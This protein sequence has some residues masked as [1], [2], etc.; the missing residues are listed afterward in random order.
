LSLL[1]RRLVGRLRHSSMSSAPKEEEEAEIQSPFTKGLIFNVCSL[2]PIILVSWATNT[3]RSAVVSCAVNYIVFAIHA[4]P[5]SSEKFFDATGTLTY[6]SLTVTAVLLSPAFEGFTFDLRQLVLGS[7]VLVWSIRLGSYLLGRICRDGK[8]ARF[9]RLKI[10]F[11]LWLGVWSMQAL[12]CYLVALPALIIISKPAGVF[13]SPSILDLVGWSIWVIGMGFEVIADRQK[14]AWRMLPE[15]KGRF[16]TVGL[17]S[18]SR[19]PNY[20]GEITLW[21][22]VCVSG[23]SSFTGFELLAWFSPVTTFILLNYV[24]GV[25][26]LEKTADERWGNEPAYQHY[27]ANTPCVFPR[28]TA[29]PEFKPSDNGVPLTEV[30]QGA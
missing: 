30:S 11:I 18:R 25:P 8:D 29:P 15:N 19:H 28:L 21:V 12:W 13:A 9:D 22:G 14:D 6:V 17:W 4:L 5:F 1:V 20:F 10:S 27:K 23:M 16:I 24:S 2:T 3:W 26:L 7:M